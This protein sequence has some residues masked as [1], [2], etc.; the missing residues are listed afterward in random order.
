MNKYILKSKLEDLMNENS[1]KF[2]QNLTNNNF[3][4][5]T[6]E[7]YHEWYFLAKEYLSQ[8]NSLRL[9]EFEFYYFNNEDNFTCIKDYIYNLDDDKNNEEEYQFLCLIMMQYSIVEYHLSDNKKELR[10]HL[11]VYNN[12]PNIFSRT[13]SSN[14]KNKI[15]LN[16][17][18]NWLNDALKYINP[19]EKEIKE[20]FL[21]YF[22]NI[23]Y[24]NQKLIDEKYNIFYYF[25]LLCSYTKPLTTKERSYEINLLKSQFIFFNILFDEIEIE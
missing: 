19:L 3:N 11:I 1:I 4:Y 23:D 20:E 10:E 17:Y 16:N 5:N 14:T 15:N 2:Y 21:K 18:L 7:T 8:I 9:K 22:I 13:F 6:F 24:V 25:M 12:D